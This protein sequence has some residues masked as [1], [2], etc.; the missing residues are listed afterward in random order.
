MRC[1]KN[2]IRQAEL[3]SFFDTSSRLC[4][5]EK[6]VGFKDFSYFPNTKDNSVR[7][8]ASPDDSSH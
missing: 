5:Q 7:I 3:F 2:G 4:N 6:I 8:I 1:V